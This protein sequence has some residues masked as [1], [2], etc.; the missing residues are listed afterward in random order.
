MKTGTET[1]RKREIDEKRLMGKPRVEMEV[2]SG[3]EG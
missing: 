3:R 2:E 1:K